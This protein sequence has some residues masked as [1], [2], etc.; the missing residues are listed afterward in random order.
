[1]PFGTEDNFSMFHVASP[2][3]IK[4]GKVT[5]VYFV[6]TEQVLKAEG[7]D[8]RVKAEI[9]TK[10][11][12]DG[13]E[14][15]VFA[16]LEEALELLDGLDVNVWTM[17]EGTMFGVDQPVMTIEGSYLAFGK[18]ETSILGFLCQASGIAT[19]AARCRK[20]AG[21]KPMI[22]FGARR[23]HPA[24]APMVERN[25]FIGG[26]DGV[27]TVASAELLGIEPSGTIPHALIIIMGNSPEALRA[28]DRALE[29][30]I[31]RIA[32]VDTFQDEKFESIAA[33][34]ALGERLYGVRLDTP[35]SRRG[36][37]ARIF[38]E[39]RWELDLRGHENIKLFASG[40]I[41]EHSIAELNH[42]VDAY[43]V[44]TSITNAPVID[45]SMDIVELEGV[46]IAKR[47]KKSGSKSVY[48]CPG[49]HST[50][51]VPSGKPFNRE[52]PCGGNYEDILRLSISGGKVTG[53]PVPPGEVR[54]FVIGQL[55]FYE[56]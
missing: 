30:H 39:V 14:W 23:M 9:S 12:P 7:V 55:E 10:G 52:C 19:K 2:D 16:G 20:A 41:D 31:S 37:F 8:K 29:D 1:M 4:S 6:R 18:Y 40:G 45:F 38:E 34:E 50:Y 25:A 33:A 47:G 17:D 32:L 22:S 54:D 24:L 21:D 15:A 13:Y 26:C 51:V 35:S 43:G 11:F 46:P 27:A 3:D 28:F 53:K 42:I 56:I 49:C 48:R 36:N 44:G 5:D